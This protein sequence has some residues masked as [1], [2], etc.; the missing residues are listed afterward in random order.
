MIP[1]SMPL[2]PSACVVIS[3]I[4]FILA[5]I[6][7]LTG[8]LDLLAA[9]L[10][11]LMLLIFQIIL[12]PIILEHPHVHQAWGGTAYNLTVAGSICIFAASIARRR[13]S[14]VL[15]RA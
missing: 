12:V 15:A 4:G 10:F 13:S 9:R 14:S 11:V 7:I 2:G 3:G 8:I 5:G 1:K 6:A